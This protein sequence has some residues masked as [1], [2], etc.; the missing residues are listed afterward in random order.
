MEIFRAYQA[1]WSTP[2]LQADADARAGNLKRQA[3]YLM[4]SSFDKDRTEQLR[5]L[6]AIEV[7]DF[8]ANACV[9]QQIRST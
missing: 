1:M 7:A 3:V 6:A 9:S 4:L 5:L 2:S 8:A